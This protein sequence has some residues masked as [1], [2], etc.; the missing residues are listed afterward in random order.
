[1]NPGESLHNT[2]V[3]PIWMATAIRARVVDSSVRGVLT[4]STSFISGAGLKKCKPA[5]RWGWG[6]FP[7]RAVREREE[8]LEAKRVSLLLTAASRGK[9]PALPPGFSRLA[10]SE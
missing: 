5:N 8:V 2:G 9:R 1:M 10:R 3:L 6:I 7:A 4:T